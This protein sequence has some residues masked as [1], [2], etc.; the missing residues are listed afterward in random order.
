MVQY[1]NLQDVLET[2]ARA[3]ETLNW[4]SVVVHT[5]LPFPVAAAAAEDI[6]HHLFLLALSSFPLA[7]WSR[8]EER[9][10]FWTT[11]LPAGSCSSSSSSSKRACSGV[12]I[13]TAVTVQLLPVQ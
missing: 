7:Q 12:M 3:H 5:V 6:E 9:N 13:K 2:N 1:N 10:Y 8:Q 4:F 11:P